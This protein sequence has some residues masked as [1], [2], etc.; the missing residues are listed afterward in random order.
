VKGLYVGADLTL[1]AFPGVGAQDVRKYAFGFA[2]K[3]LVSF[4]VRKYAP[5]VPFRLHVN[6]GGIIDG[7]GDLV[8]TTAHTATPAEEYALGLHKYNRLSFGAGIE[9]P[10]P[11]V[12][13]FVEYG[14][15]FPLGTSTL[16]GPDLQPVTTDASMPQQ[17]TIGLKV[18]APRDL[19]ILLACEIGLTKYVALGVPATPP[20]NL[21][22]GLSYAFDPMAK[23]TSKVVE[24]TVTVE[25]KV[26]VA[27]PAPVY[28]GKVGGTVVDAETKQP[29]A[30]A[31]VAM[32]GTGLP[33]VATD[34]DGGKYLSHELPAGKIAL[35]FARDGY[36]PAALEATIEAGKVSTLQAQLTR[37]VKN[38]AVKL[39]LVSGKQKAG[40]KITFVGP[41]NTEMVVAN[42]GGTIELPKGHYAASVES[43]G[44]LSK[45]Q[46]FEVPEGGTMA[47][48][49]E[50]ALKP[51]LSLVVVKQDRIEIK[52]QVHFA[53]AKATILN[54]SFQLLDQVID[55]LVRA[56]IKKLRIEGH[57][58]NQGAKDAN[59]KLSQARAASVADYLVKKGVDRARIVSEG[60]G[61]TK[62]VAPNLTARGRELNR[63]VEFMI[64]E[65]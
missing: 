55:A 64:L 4:D 33:P 47:V 51:K 63:R 10:L 25:K 57:T 41:K 18:T 16:L 52:Q 31:V 3:L 32:S 43:E 7:T 5:K 6:F 27:T 65:K 58:D 24:K 15:A 61:D 17:L 39:T 20:Y 9:A 13:P 46:E 53:T 45:I 37:E 28:T 62:P 60:F 44:Y 56:N 29:I 22:F 50:L 19:T 34:V 14:F 1:I 12:T 59:L 49:I 36:R 40:G 11:W 48:S 42:D 35:T 23:G 21:V 38:A 54:D 30:G 2:P 26:E 8:D